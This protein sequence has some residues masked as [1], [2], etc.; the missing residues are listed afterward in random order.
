MK[1]G[2]VQVY[3]GNGKGKTTAAFGLCLRAA[4]HG[5]KACVVQFQKGVRCGEHAGA[6]RL[7]ID[8][9]QCLRGRGSGRCGPSCPLIAE[10]LDIF[11]NRAP[12]VVVMDEIMAALK[13][14]CVA[15]SDVCRVLE[16][17]PPGT[18]LVMTGRDAPEWLMERA[19]LVTR[20]E[21]VKHYFDT[22]LPAREGIEY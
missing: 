15:K 12:D 9:V 13:H 5:M 22:G 7:G 3:T 6:E 16:M 11:K 17:R 14:G 4:G 19:D 21:P 18:E 2:R 20:M 1:E 8:V 10:V